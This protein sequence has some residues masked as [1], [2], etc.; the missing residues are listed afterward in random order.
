MVQDKVTTADQYKVV[1]RSAP[2]SMTLTTP[3]P[4]VKV[5]PIFNAEYLSNGRR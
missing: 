5:T 2:F 3:N 1:Y 4:D